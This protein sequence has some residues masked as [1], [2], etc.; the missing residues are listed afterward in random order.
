MKP[1]QLR[2]LQLELLNILLDVQ[3]VC[4]K[5][6]ICFYLG[7]GS[8]LGAVR[9]QGFIPWDDDIDILMKREDYERF[10]SIASEELGDR[11]V[12]QHPSTVSAYWSTFLKIRVKDTSPRFSSPGCSPAKRA[13]PACK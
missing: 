13:C 10:L 1:E 4:E 12:I 11:Y 5:Q 6:R 9:H 7:E 8:L 3:K 2:T